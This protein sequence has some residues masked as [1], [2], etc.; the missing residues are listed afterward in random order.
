M[1]IWRDLHIK[2]TNTVVESVTTFIRLLICSVISFMKREKIVG[3]R[4]SKVVLKYIIL[5]SKIYHL[6]AFIDFHN[7]GLLAFKTELDQNH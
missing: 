5:F 3:D 7:R 1:F 4:L 6:L 2:N